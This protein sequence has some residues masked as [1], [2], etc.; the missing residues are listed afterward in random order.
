M[1]KLNAMV[2]F[3]NKVFLEYPTLYPTNTHSLVT[4]QYSYQSDI[5]PRDMYMSGWYLSVSAKSQL[6][7][8]QLEP[9]FKISFLGP[10]F[11]DVNCHS[12]ICQSNI[13]HGYDISAISQL[14]LHHKR[15]KDRC[16]DP[17]FELHNHIDYARQREMS[18]ALVTILRLRPGWSQG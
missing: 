3:K 11:T 14:L 13:W 2:K 5:C 16:S 6:L 1:F 12:D 8:T 7:L 10:S 4:V 15:R 9:N 18:E 17:E